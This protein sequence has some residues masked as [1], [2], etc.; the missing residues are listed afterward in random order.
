MPNVGPE[1]VKMILQ[2]FVEELDDRDATELASVD[3]WADELRGHLA[4]RVR[5][6][7]ER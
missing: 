6:A 2:E 7:D 3:A 5:T 1:A 4:D